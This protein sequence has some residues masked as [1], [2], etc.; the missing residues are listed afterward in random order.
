MEST[1]LRDAA[2]RNTLLPITRATL[3]VVLIYILGGLWVTCYRVIL[4]AKF[5]PP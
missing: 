3:H 1:A 2:V 5:I 4:R